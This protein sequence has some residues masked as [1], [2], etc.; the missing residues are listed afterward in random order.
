MPFQKY[1][2]LKVKKQNIERIL[3]KL[4]YDLI[5]FYKI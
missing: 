5:F 3:I 1:S 4:L 2:L